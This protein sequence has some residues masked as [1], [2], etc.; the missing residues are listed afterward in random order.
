MPPRPT[1]RQ[2]AVLEAMSRGRPLFVWLNGGSAMGAETINMRVTRALIA[3][4]WI[5]PEKAG[6][7]I[8]Y[9][10]EAGRRAVAREDGGV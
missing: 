4:G 2:R 8:H 6:R 10:T 5:A 3:N 9:I 7:P 1:P